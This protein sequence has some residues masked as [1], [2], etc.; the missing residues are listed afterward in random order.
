MTDRDT[1]QH[2]HQVELV[3]EAQTR[4]IERASSWLDNPK[5]KAALMRFNP[6]DQDHRQA[7]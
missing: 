3:N 4:M 7:S 2:E 1:S 6:E 5:V